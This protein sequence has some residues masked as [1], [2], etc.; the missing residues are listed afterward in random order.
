LTLAHEEFENRA[1]ETQF[2]YDR[3]VGRH[4]TLLA[5]FMSTA[6]KRLAREKELFFG[7]QEALK[8]GGRLA[9]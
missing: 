9:A 2:R 4:N 6:M 1:G 3:A 7:A 5:R 8:Q